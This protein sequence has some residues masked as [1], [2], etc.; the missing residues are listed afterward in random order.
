MG[1]G[2]AGWAAVKG[3]GCGVVG[4]IGVR[5]GA[6]S[7]AVVGCGKWGWGVVEWGCGGVR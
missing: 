5:C 4:W 1:C 3:W 6:I 7:G 2:G